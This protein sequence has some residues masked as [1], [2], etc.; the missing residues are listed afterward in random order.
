MHKEELLKVDLTYRPR[1][2]GRLHFC[3]ARTAGVDVKLPSLV[4]RMD[5]AIG[6]IAKLHRSSREGLEFAP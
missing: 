2:R 5:V 1:R 6:R 3:A 4:A